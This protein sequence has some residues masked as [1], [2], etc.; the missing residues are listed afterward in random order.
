MPELLFYGGSALMAVSLLAAV[1]SGVVIR[2]SKK[3][4]KTQLDEEYGAEDI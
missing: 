4:L 1:V 3:R 2:M